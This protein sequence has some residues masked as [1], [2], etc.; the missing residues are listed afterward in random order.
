MPVKDIAAMLNRSLSTIYKEIRKGQTIVYGKDYIKKSVYAAEVAQSKHEYAQTSKGR[1][2][3]LGADYNFA[4]FIQAKISLDKFSPAAALAAAREH[5]FNTSVCV[6]TLYSYIDKGY[7][8]G[9]TNK[10]LLLKTKITPKYSPVVRISHKHPEYPNI[11]I[12]P[13]FVNFRQELGHWEMDLII[14]K[15]STGSVLLT[16]V[17]RVTRSVIIRRLPSKHMANVVNALDEL[18]RCYSNF[19]DVFKSITVDNGSE[20]MDYFGMTTSIHGGKRTEVYYCHPYAS[21]ERGSNENCNRIIRRWIPKGQ[22]IGQYSDDYIQFVQDWI[23]N[24][25]RKIL[26]YSTAAACARAWLSA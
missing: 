4:K 14:G 18:E 19:S 23:N 17:E 6:S 9:V 5:G 22:D 8:P 10:D 26:G 16:L 11:S 24:Y 7:I 3:K 12:R 13:N 25:P 2:I 21:C 15:K 1:P 20:F